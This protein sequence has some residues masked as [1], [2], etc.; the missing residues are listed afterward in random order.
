MLLMYF[1]IFSLKVFNLTGNYSCKNKNQES[2]M[3]ESRCN[4]FVAV[5]FV[6]GNLL[7]NGVE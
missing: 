7:T 1:R 3:Q 5:Q 4:A 2:A 6:E